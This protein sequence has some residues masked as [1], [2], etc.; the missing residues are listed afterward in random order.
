MNLDPNK[1]QYTDAFEDSYNS[2]VGDGQQ[3]EYTDKKV[4][5]VVTFDKNNQIKMYRNGE[6][7]G[8]MYRGNQGCAE[9]SFSQAACG[10]VLW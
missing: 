3:L 5:L 2:L 1:D 4:Q 6:P 9:D 8:D 7:Y 10:P